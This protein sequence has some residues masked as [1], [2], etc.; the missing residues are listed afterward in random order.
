MN[1]NELI[2]II[3]PVYNVC[4][5]LET[6]IKSIIFQDYKNLEIIL[7]DDGSTDSSGLI[8]DKYKDIDERIKVIHKENGGLSDARN[9]GIKFSSGKYIGFVD[10]DDW[11]SKSMYSTLIKMCQENKASI[12]VCE[13]ILVEPNYIINDGKSEQILVTDTNE[14]LDILYK[15]KKYYSHAW[16][17]L[18]KREIF[19]NLE[20]PKGKTFED[21]R[22]MHEVFSK[23]ERI[24]F[25]DKGL[26]YYRCRENSIARVNNYEMWR[27]YFDAYVQ[28][29]NSKFTKGREKYLYSNLLE[30]AEYLKSVDDKPKE[31][32]GFMINKKLMK[33]FSLSFG[34]KILVRTFIVCY[35]PFLIIVYKKIKKNEWLKRIIIKLINYIKTNRFFITGNEKHIILMGS[36]EYNN[37]G[38]LAIAYSIKNFIRDRCPDYKYIEIPE[39]ALLNKKYPINVKPHD[40]LL[41]I[42]GGNFGDVY[43]DQQ[44]I[45]KRIIKK[46]YKNKIIVMPQTI[47]FTKTDSGKEEYDKIYKL[48]DKNSNVELFAREI[49]SYDIFKNCFPNSKVNLCPDMVLTNSFDNINNRKGV[50]VLL[51]RDREAKLSN[52]DREQII[53]SLFGIKEEIVV[54]DT[55]L[56][57]SVKINDR[58]IEVQQFI[59]RISRFK[60]VVTDRL[61]GVIFCAITGT[62]CIAISN[63][64]HKVKGIFEWISN[65]G[66]IDLEDDINLVWEKGKYLMAK[67]PNGSDN[68]INQNLFNNLEVTIKR[69]LE[70]E[71]E[72]VH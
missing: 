48:L 51:R 67:Y 54:D 27:S 14:A 35:I 36:P 2:S 34:I 22:I 16:N 15:N 13:R 38:D 44:I 5:Y 8:C 33:F 1:S 23:A 49:F 69:S 57:Y 9:V 29:G 58:D 10:S 32:S 30:V 39:S 70:D 46:Y 21:I 56:S 4:E 28:R 71:Y 26:Y 59:N 66:F 3:V 24:V 53:S 55:C 12:A 52:G 60:L 42:G 40:L 37:L 62:P 47:D 17:K 20:F 63:N 72:E 65:L 19:E 50:L 61:H 45:R 18:Y 6:C 68:R 41:L 43:M 25:I 31:Y 11:V 64:N 7:V